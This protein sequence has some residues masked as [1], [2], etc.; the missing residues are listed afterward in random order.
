MQRTV[1]DIFCIAYF[2]RV[3]FDAHGTN[4]D[5]FKAIDVSDSD[6]VERRVV[7]LRSELVDLVEID[8][9]FHFAQRP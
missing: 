8:D 7:T 9:V 5:Y 2:F 4:A 1:D 3:R 6:V